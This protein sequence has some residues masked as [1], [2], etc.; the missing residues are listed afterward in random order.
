M[1]YISIFILIFSHS[2]FA[3]DVVHWDRVTASYAV[4]ND[5]SSVD[6]SAAK[7]IS[8]SLFITGLYQ[9]VEDKT[10]FRFEPEKYKGLHLGIGY[11]HS[12]SDDMEFFSVISYEL[13]EVYTDGIAETTPGIGIGAGFRFMLT[14][15]LEVSTYLQSRLFARHFGLYPDFH[16][17]ISYLASNSV[18]VGLSY[19]IRA[20]KVHLSY[21]F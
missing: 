7:L 18:S 1:R 17:S 8:E 21:L 15:Q 16:V 10:P 4:D 14:E 12:F 9:S 3:N 6:I 2:S 11:R 19:G 20:S 13:V 5:F